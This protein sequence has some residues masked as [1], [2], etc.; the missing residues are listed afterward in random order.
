[1]RWGS[2]HV[3]GSAMAITRGTENTVYRGYNFGADVTGTLGVYRNRWYAAAEFG[4]DKAVITYI[5]HT[6]WY[7]THFYPDADDGWYLDAGGTFHYG[8]TTGLTVGRAQLFG[9]FGFLRTEDFNDVTPPMYA[10]M[11]IGIG[12]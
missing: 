11:G 6:D 5:E 9:R 3:T 12:F 1:M 8:L 4:K 10:S 7:R 2:L